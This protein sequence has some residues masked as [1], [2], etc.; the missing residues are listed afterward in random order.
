MGAAT[1]DDESAVSFTKHQPAAGDAYSSVAEVAKASV[2]GAPAGEAPEPVKQAAPIGTIL[3]WV[4]ISFL[5]GL[6]LNVMPCVLPVIG[7]KI[8]S[9]VSQAGSHRLQIFYLN[10]WLSLG[11]I[12]VF[13]LLG[14]LAVVFGMAWS[15]HFTNPIF[16]VVLTGI[17]FAFGL[18]FLGVWEVPIPGFAGSSEANQ[19]AQREGA[20][21]AFF[22]GVLSTVLATPCAGPMMIPALAFATSQPAGIALGM[23]AAMG[24]GMASPYLLI[25]I[26]PKLIR[27]LPSP[28]TGW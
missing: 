1:G 20:I 5:A 26:F 19:L 18:S 3:Y 22:K 6:I 11:I 16:V 7:L 10:V 21:G 23:F 13:M 24:I 14:T 17:V 9:L 8:M 2:W 25:G 28:A 27:W 12:F 15:D 4:G